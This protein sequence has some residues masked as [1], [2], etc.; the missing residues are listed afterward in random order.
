VVTILGTG[1]MTGTV[2]SPTVVSF[3]PENSGNVISGDTVLSV[4]PTPTSITS[5]TITVSAPSGNQVNQVVTY[6]VTVTTAAGTSQPLPIF[7]Y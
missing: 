6:Y 7:T 1:F 4:T 2:S 3:T 5:S